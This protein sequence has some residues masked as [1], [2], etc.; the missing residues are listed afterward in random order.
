MCDFCT[1]LQDISHTRLRV[2]SFQRSSQDCESSTVRRTLLGEKLLTT[3]E[4]GSEQASENRNS[5]INVSTQCSKQL[6][7][8]MPAI[9]GTM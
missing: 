4:V 2:I 6:Q 5:E 7:A 8:I 9:I 3:E 1:A